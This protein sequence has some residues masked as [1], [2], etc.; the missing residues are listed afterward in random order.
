MKRLVGATLVLGLVASGWAQTV[1]VGLNEDPDILDPVL[2]C[3]YVGRIV[4]ASLCDKLFDISQD[5]DIVPQLATGYEFSADNLSLT[6]DIRDGVVF[7]DG[8]SLDAEAVKYNLD[9]AKNFPGS[10]RASEIEQLESVEVVDENTVRLAM[11]QPFAPILAQLADRA[12]MMVS[13]TAAEAAGENFGNAPVCAGPFSFVERV[14]QDR[15]V[16]ERFENYW[17][18]GS[19]TLEQI[20]FLPIPDTSVRLANLQAGDLE[21]IERPAPTDLE[22]IRSDPNLELP[23]APSLGYQGLTINLSN[24]E[25]LDTPLASSPQVR[26]ALELALDRSVINQAVFN[27]EY[28]VGNQ[29]VPPSSLWYNEDYPVPERNVEQAQAL[30]QEAGFERVAFEMMVG[31]DPQSVR[32]GEVIQAL[33]T[34]A[35]FDISLR[36]T[37]F[38]SALDFQEAGDYEVFQVGWSGR[39]DPDGNIHQYNTC[40]GAL[41]ENGFCNKEVDALLNEA[42]SVVDPAERKALYNQAGELYL[43][44]RHI[45][46]LYHQNLFFP[47]VAALTGFEAYPDGLIRW[48]GV[49]LN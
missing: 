41:N 45:I 34:E 37:E 28:I 6:I 7:H 19:I 5:L 11:S 2:S 13:P 44:N 22:A 1:R 15:I 23:T 9:R 20:I 38:A 26:E 39:L 4:F 46:Y 8:T 16:V 48:Q 17:D 24:P 49:T 10:N 32:L 47:H 31:N 42:R 33:G 21:M 27:G 12:G 30:L 14:A 3:T 40:D 29:A 43:P 36:A 25:P 18:A 35:G